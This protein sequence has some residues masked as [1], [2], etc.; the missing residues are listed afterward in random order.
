MKNKHLFLLPATIAAG[1]TLLSPN[2]HAAAIT[3]DAGGVDNNWSTVDNWSDNAAAT[4]DDI[5]FNAT[6]ALASGITN[7]VDTSISI[8]SLTYSQESATL[9]HTTAI[10]AGQTLTVA[11]NF[12]LAGSSTTAATPT[13]VT[14]TGSTGTLTVS[15][16]SFQVG[17]TTP[18]ASGAPTNSLDMSGL[19]TFNANLGNTGIFRLGATNSNTG[20]AQATVKLA[21]TSSITADVLGVGDRAG[22]GVSQTLKLGSVANT[23]NANTVA[24]GSSSGRGS[25]NLSFETST[26][27][28]LLRAADGI[29]A[30]T[31]MNMVNNGFNHNGTHTAVVDFSAHS[32][33]AKIGALTMARRTGTGSAGSNATLTF[34]TGTLEVASVNM[35]VATNASMTGA[36]NATINIGG[37]TATFGAISM[38]TNNG[39]GGTTAA[40]NFTGGSITVTGDITRV[41]GTGAGAIVATL[42]LSGAS[43]VLDVSG[44]NLTGLT[45]ITYTNGL[46][47]NLG[48]VNTGM[49]LAGSGSRVFDQAAGISGQIQGA[50]T[51]TGLGLTKQGEGSLTLSGTNTFTG[52]VTISTGELKITNASALGTGPKIINAQNL[53]YVS[54]DGTAGN[55]SLASSLSFTTAGL[56]ILNTAGDNVISGTVKTIAGNGSSTITSDGGS[57][58][59]AGNVDSGATGNRILE[60]SGTSTGTNTVSGSISNGTATLAVTKSGAGNWTLT[61]ATN[62]YTGATNINGGKLVVDGNIST[63]SLTT[64]ASGATLAGSGTVGKTVINGTLAVGNSPGQMDFT[65]TLVLAGTTIMEIDGTLGAGVTGGHDFVNLT[66]AGAAGVLTYGGAMTLDIGVIFGTGTY[67]WNLFDMASETGTFATLSLGDQYSGSLMDADLNGIWDLTSGDNTWQFTESTGELGLT[68]IPEP[69]AALL[70]GVGVLALLRRRR[71]C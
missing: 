43:T 44:K 32:V 59:L 67:S 6:G 48:T 65:D 66:G 35:A 64:V 34:D 30:V 24:I 28:L 42:A 61:N 8:A 60:L 33:D 25:G 38:A 19:G 13:N 62:S 15:G 70:G 23:I 53:G 11:G 46:L 36:N 37:G 52:G 12:L 69:S 2:L 39:G 20:G 47:K 41:G 21:A 26:G 10:A 54:L 4:G 31:T 9:Q 5:T 40:L 55:I 7:T 51:G 56:S 22:R 27:T 57:L 58:T 1:F 16:T 3:W 14:L 18:G 71:S 68:V 50:I 45:S 63:S 49:T 17:Q 29:A